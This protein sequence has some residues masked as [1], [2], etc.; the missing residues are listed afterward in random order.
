M[1]WRY[2]VKLVTKTYGKLVSTL[3]DNE[4]PTKE[5]PSEEYFENATERQKEILRSQ[6]KNAIVHGLRPII[7]TVTHVLDKY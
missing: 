7:M 6:I 2:D 3:T 5:L 1:D 4:V